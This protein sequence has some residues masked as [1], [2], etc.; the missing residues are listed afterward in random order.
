MPNRI[1]AIIPS[2]GGRSTLLRW[3]IG[4]SRLPS[5]FCSTRNMT[6]T[7]MAFVGEIVSASSVAGIIENSGPKLGMKLNNPDDA[8]YKRQ[9]HADDRQPDPCRDGDDGHGH[10]LPDQPP[11]QRV[12]HGAQDLT[13]AQPVAG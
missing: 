11:L 7:A 3:T 4:V 6:I 2:A 13:G 8:E 10:A 9:R 5:R 1:C 12:A